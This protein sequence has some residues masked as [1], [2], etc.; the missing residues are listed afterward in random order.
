VARIEDALLN[1]PLVN[2]ETMGGTRRGVKK[3][4]L[5]KKNKEPN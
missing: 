1:L 5:A 2:S 3:D 4:K